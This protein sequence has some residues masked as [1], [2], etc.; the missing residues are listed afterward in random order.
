VT[1]PGHGLVIASGPRDPRLHDVDA[2]FREVLI[3]L[4]DLVA[5]AARQ[6]TRPLHPTSVGARGV[7]RVVDDAASPAQA[8]FRPGRTFPVVGRYSNSHG[9]DDQEV[10]VRGLSLRLLET[11][12][13]LA[14]GLLDITFSTG[15]YFFAPDADAFRHLTAGTEAQRDAYLAAHPR[16]RALFWDRMRTATSYPAYEFHSQT[17]RAFVAEDGTHLLARYRVLPRHETV[18]P[19]HHDPGDEWWPSTAPEPGFRPPV[20]P[21]ALRDDLRSRLGSGGV[22]GVLQVQLHPVGEDADEVARALDATRPW[23]DS[24]TWSDLATFRF[25]HPL[26]QDET[27]ALAFDPALAPPELNIALSSSPRSTASVDHLRALIYRMSALARRG[28]PLTGP[29]AELLRP[30]PERPRTTGR[31]V[32]VIGAGPGGLAAARELE[33]NGHRAV[34]LDAAPRVAGKAASV[35][36]DGHPHD[37]GAH[38]CTSRYR[39]LAALAAEVGVA[40]EP[41]PAEQTLTVGPSGRTAADTSFFTDGSVQRYEALRA[42]LFPRIGEPGLAHSLDALS[43]PLSVWLAEHGLH[44]MFATFG[45]GYTCSGYGFLDDDLPALYFVKYAEMTGLL[46]DTARTTGDVPTRFTIEGGFGALWERVARD[47]RDVRPGTTVRSVH[48][49][50]DGVVVHTDRGTVEADDLLIAVPPDRIAHVLDASEEERRWAEQVRYQRYRTTVAGATGLPRDAFYLLGEFADA[51]SSRG[52]CV[53]FQHRYPDSDVYTCYS[54]L[55]ADTAGQLEHDLAARGAR[56]FREH[57]HRDWSFMPH[58]TGDDLAALAELEAGQGRRRTYYTGGLLGFELV[59]CVVSHAQDLVRREFPGAGTVAA[60]DGAAGPPTRSAAEIRGWLVRS[61]AEAAGVAT[62]SVGPGDALSGFA[63]DSLTLADLMSRL[64]TYLGFR[65]PH[66]L[67]LQLPTVDA[68]A[69]HLAGKGAASPVEDWQSSVRRSLTGDVTP[70]FCVSGIGAP[71]GYFRPLAAALGSEPPLYPLE[72]PG[73]PDGVG[74]PLDDVEEIAAEFVGQIR[75]LVPDGPYRL[76]GHSFGGVVAY[77]VGR[78]LRAAGAEVAPVTLLDTFVA[79]ADQPALA[80]D[81]HGALRALVVMRHMTCVGTG[82]CDCG[83]DLDRPLTEQR[84]AVARALG[85]TDPDRYD[86]HLAALIDVQIDSVRAYADYPFPPS[87]LTVHVVRTA[88]GFAAMPAEHLGLR[89]HLDSPANGWEH[90]EVGALA[91]FPVSGDHFSMFRAPHVHEV[92]DAVRAGEPRGGRLAA[93]R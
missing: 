25:D 6:R 17:P 66:T 2:D 93:V 11:G 12:A 13:D 5:F 50:D 56:G 1:G 63:L 77:E 31:T 40:T 33:R 16:L 7:L 86:E 54:Y 39:R 61:I 59:E 46:S 21:A 65:V 62:T 73:R 69:A 72:I 90:V 81:E 48:R 91:V 30:V 18:R 55:G 38:I 35:D 52:H 64:S 92:T 49:H 58:F 83:V 57:L 10:S 41:T 84:T 76:G 60:P 80:D 20:L 4:S 88:D 85:A 44:S 29:L 74:E 67:F 32:C 34:V 47:L 42:T 89:L 70:F 26:A 78:Q 8:F 23:P 51:G 82:A 9:D 14:S 53:G 87:D 43:A 75:A 79:A 15:A 19:G 3:G 22:D 71:A 45:L 68:V 37:L 28:E 24:C 27:D 36:F